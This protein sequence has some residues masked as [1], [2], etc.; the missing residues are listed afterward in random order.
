MA[1]NVLATIATDDKQTRHE[2]YSRYIH[3]SK[4]RGK[5]M[6]MINTRERERKN[7]EDLALEKMKIE[8][9]MV[10]SINCM[11]VEMH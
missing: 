4:G 3:G 1:R 8:L 2:K 9:S 11:T 5:Q 6:L 7:A 10:C